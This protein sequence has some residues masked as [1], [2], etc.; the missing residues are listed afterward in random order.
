MKSIINCVI[1]LASKIVPLRKVV[2]FRSFD[3][4]Y[5]DSPKAV[6]ECL[7]EERPDI[8]Q[9]WLV[10]K[11]TE[12][13]LPSY[14]KE[15]RIGSYSAVFHS[16]TAAAFID[17]NYGRKGVNITENNNKVYISKLIVWLNTTRNQVNLSTWHG[18]PLKR[19]GSDQPGA[20]AV[21]FLTPPL[22]M[23]HPNRHTKTV[24]ERITFR[25]IQSEVMGLPRNDILLK[26]GSTEDI[27]KKL[28]LPKDIKIVLYAPTFR[29]DGHDTDDK[30]IERSGLSQLKEIQFSKLFQTLTLSFGGEE[31]AFVG[32]FHYF[33]DN[34]IDWNNLSKEDKRIVNGNKHEDMNEYLIA[35]DVLI[36]DCSSCMFDYALMKKPVFLFF[37]D[38]KHYENSE[39]GFYFDIKQMPFPCATT[40]DNLIS[41][42]SNFNEGEYEKNLEIMFD[43]LGNEDD[44]YASQRVVEYMLRSS[45]CLA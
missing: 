31:W 7:H 29:S 37:P 40:F 33:V 44:G 25:K 4:R 32:R 2:V 28:G 42:I 9:I 8:K 11:K 26:T 6:S 45:K 23:T 14:I 27:K 41:E 13:S 38:L 39:R 36:T 12:G 22:V 10:N 20:T 3:G 1:L 43:E 19:I 17:N 21:D 18:T 5:S 30:N 24:L 35:A 34:V 15:V 16:A